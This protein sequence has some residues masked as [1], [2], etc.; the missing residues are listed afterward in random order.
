MVIKKVVKDTVV[1]VVTPFMVGGTKVI[2]TAFEYGMIIEFACAGYKA[3]KAVMKAA[4]SGADK[5]LK[6]LKAKKAKRPET[7]TTEQPKM[8]NPELTQE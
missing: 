8:D 2:I 3:G 6:N 5:A 1:E 7:T 4:I